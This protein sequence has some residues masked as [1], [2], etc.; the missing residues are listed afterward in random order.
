M[1][2][3]IFCVCALQAKVSWERM[4][5]R[6]TRLMTRLGDYPE[7]SRELIKAGDLSRLFD[8]LISEVPDPVE[9]Q[10]YGHLLLDICTLPLVLQIIGSLQSC[11]DSLC[12]NYFHV[13]NINT[14]SLRTLECS[15]GVK[16]PDRNAQWRSSTGAVL[17]A[18]FGKGFCDAAVMNIRSSACVPRCL[19]SLR[20]ATSFSIAATVDVLGVVV[21]CICQSARLSHLLLDDF[22]T[23]HGYAF[24]TTF[25]LELEQRWA[26][27]ESSR[28]AFKLDIAYCPL[29]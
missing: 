26:C 13:M 8:M 22:R 18:L 2:F 25:V 1:V 19:Q 11:E 29:I 17:R 21:T 6:V 16:V 23:W 20:T 4:H 3:R 10:F 14:K 15:F 24:L 28:V 12:Q 5:G 9:A 27:E 7:V